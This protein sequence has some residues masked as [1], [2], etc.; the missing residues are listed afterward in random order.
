M[1]DLLKTKTGMKR[2]NVN[3]WGKTADDALCGKSL[4]NCI[5]YHILGQYDIFLSSVGSK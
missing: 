5:S 3:E 2:F 4:I 1:A